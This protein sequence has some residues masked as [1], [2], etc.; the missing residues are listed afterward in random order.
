MHNCDFHHGGKNHFNR[1]DKGIIFL[2]RVF[3]LNQLPEYTVSQTR[4]SP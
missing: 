4:I 1:P 2:L 3:K